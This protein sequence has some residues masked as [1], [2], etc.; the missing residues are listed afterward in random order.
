MVHG[1]LNALCLFFTCLFSGVNKVKIIISFNSSIIR[2][3]RLLPL[4]CPR[5][6]P[7]GYPFPPPIPPNP[8]R[9]AKLGIP[10]APAPP[11]PPIIYYIISYIPSIFPIS[12]I[13][14]IR[15]PIPP[16]YCSNLGSIAFDIY[17]I[18]CLGLR[19]KLLASVL[20]FNFIS[21]IFLTILANFL[22]S[23]RRKLTS[24]GLVPEPLAIRV[25]LV[26]FNYFTQSSS[27]LVIESI[28]HRNLFILAVDSFSLPG[29][30]KLDDN[31]GIMLTT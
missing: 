15:L 13:I 10:P 1:P 5:G 4:I 22:Y 14:F 29:G 20:E 23:S 7:G 30:I 12:F 11:A 26:S 27:S 25:I 2:N 17:S 3:H 21:P 18:N 31:P 28:M 6:I 8:A 16:I 9:P 19:F 24:S